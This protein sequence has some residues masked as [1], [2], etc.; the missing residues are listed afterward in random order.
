M[1]KEFLVTSV[2]ASDAQTEVVFSLLDTRFL[3]PQKGGPGDFFPVQPPSFHYALREYGTR[4]VLSY[5]E[6]QE[7]GLRVRDKMT[8]EL[9]RA[10][11]DRLKIGAPARE[12]GGQTSEVLV[13]LSL[14][15]RVGLL[16]SSSPFQ[17]GI[18]P[19]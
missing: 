7:S 1:R 16:R 15:L 12:A 9:S 6:Y 8:L 2:S 10:K 3:E 17:L 19:A 11:P 5:L 13:P 14:A 18:N 4:I